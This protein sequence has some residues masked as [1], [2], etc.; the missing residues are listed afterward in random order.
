MQRRQAKV[1]LGDAIDNALTATQRQALCA[2]LGGL[3]L[4]E[5]ARRLGKSRGAV[6]K[7]LHDARKR[8]R[9]HIEARGLALDDLLTGEGAS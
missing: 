9:A 5:V 6:Y 2:E 1:V 8:L 3:P 7:L 4:V